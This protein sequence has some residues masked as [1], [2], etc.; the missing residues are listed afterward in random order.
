MQLQDELAQLSPRSVH[1]VADGGGHHIH[2]DQP[3]LVVDAVTMVLDFA[4]AR[5]A[6]SPPAGGGTTWLA[7]N[8]GTWRTD[9]LHRAPAHEPALRA[10]GEQPAALAPAA[11]H[12]AWTH[13]PGAQRVPYLQEVAYRR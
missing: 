13:E 7:F 9:N 10:S 5:H 4:R 1:L 11:G 8:G 12:P 3:Q 2:L 6:G